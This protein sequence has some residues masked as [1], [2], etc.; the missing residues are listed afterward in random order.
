MTPEQTRYVK[1]CVAERNR[2]K[3][4]V[5]TPWVNLRRRVI[6]MDHNECQRCRER[7][8]YTQATMV[9]HVNH[10]ED[11][12]DLALEVYYTDSDGERRRNLISLCHDCHMI[13]HG[14]GQRRYKKPLTRERW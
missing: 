9:H 6:E 2:H 7:G 1:R 14:W 11:R 12:P 10:V 5:W 13:E 3:F 8:R 4:Y